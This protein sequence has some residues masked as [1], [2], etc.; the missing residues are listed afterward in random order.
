MLSN[1]TFGQ[2]YPT[3]SVV[4]KMDAR[5]KILLMILYIVTVFLVETYSGYIA[6]FLVLISTVIVAKIPFHSVLKSI[7]AVLFLILFTTIL[8]VFFYKGD[9]TV[10]WSW[11]IF[12]V[13]DGGLIFAGKI[14]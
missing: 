14:N 8:N 5:V 3:R 2:Y 11:W 6:T 1:V 10:E 9:Y 4:H 13:T 7:K 12:H